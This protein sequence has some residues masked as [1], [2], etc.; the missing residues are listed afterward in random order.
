MKRF[1]TIKI[2]A[3]Y[4]SLLG[5]KNQFLHTL[6]CHIHSLLKKAFH[7]NTAV[8]ATQFGDNAVSAVLITAF[9]NLQISIM[10]TCSKHTPAQI[11]RQIVNVFKFL[12]MFSGFCGFH[13]LQDL[14]IRSSTKN[15]VY[16]WN[17][18]NNF[19]FIALCHTS[20][21]DQNF[22]GTGFLIFCHFKDRIHTF[23]FGVSD[24]A[25]GIYN[26]SIC[27][28]LIVNNLMTIPGKKPQHFF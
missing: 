8:P 24:K 3:I 11:F 26:N 10:T 27:H 2:L 22:T 28:C 9:C 5:Y 12:E 23:L 15:G 16:L 4:C 18:L 25:A 14:P 20:C 6:F 7:R 19:F 13:C 1:L 21:N 17:L